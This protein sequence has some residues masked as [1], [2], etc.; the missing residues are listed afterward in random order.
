ML[1]KITPLSRENGNTHVAPS[2]IWVK[3][4]GGGGGVDSHKRAWQRNKAKPSQLLGRLCTAAAAGRTLYVQAVI[5]RNLILTFKFHIVLARLC[6][7]I[8]T[9]IWCQMKEDE[10]NFV[11]I[12]TICYKT[13][14]F[15]GKITAL[16]GFLFIGTHYIYIYIYIFFFFLGGGA[17]NVF[18]GVRMNTVHL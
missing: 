10:L 18:A 9:H 12:K 14:N 1:P 7:G 8:T 15:S 13:F 17:L 4:W 6:V 3:G 16:S 2:C 11:T 5:L